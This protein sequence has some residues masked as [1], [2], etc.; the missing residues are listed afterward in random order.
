[1]DLTEIRLIFDGGMVVLIW[2]VQLIVYPSFKYCNEN[3]LVSWHKKYSGRLAIIVIPLMFGQL[4]ISII[5]LFERIDYSNSLY[6]ILVWSLWIITFVLFVPL[7]GKIANGTGTPK[8][9]SIL[10][11]YNWIRT[12]MW[13][14]LFILS[15]YFRLCKF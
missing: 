1:M 15:V 3:H 2:M 10:I 8:T 9:L 13:S 7:H 12:L 14:L 11:T 4:L 5:Q 6:A